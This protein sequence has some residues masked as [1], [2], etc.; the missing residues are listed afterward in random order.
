MIKQ[1]DLKSNRVFV[2][3]VVKV[4]QIGSNKLCGKKNIDYKIAVK[5]VSFGVQKA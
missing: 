3:D 1:G 4:Y 2:E 5:K